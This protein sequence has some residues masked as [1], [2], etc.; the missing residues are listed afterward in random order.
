M[1]RIRVQSL[2]K[3]LKVDVLH[4]MQHLKDDLGL[5]VT[6]LSTL[7]EGTASQVRERMSQE[8]AQVEEL[9]IGENV[10]RRRRVAPAAQPRPEAPPEEEASAP[11]AAPEE[12]PKAK[13]PKTSRARVVKLP[14]KKAA[15]ARAKKAAPTPPPAEAAPPVSEAEPPTTPAEVPAETRAESGTSRGRAAGI[16]GRQGLAG[17]PGDRCST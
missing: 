17:T 15:P 16:R 7:D 3:E 10:K 5:Q 11:P 14:S 9:R 1:A 2:A 6:Y 8:T 13:R 4:L 12:I